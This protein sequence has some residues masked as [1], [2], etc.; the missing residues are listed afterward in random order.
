MSESIDLSGYE[1]L[2]SRGFRIERGWSDELATQ[3]VD[4]SQEPEIRQF[5]PSDADERF[6]TVDTA[7]EWYDAK[8]PSVYAL[9]RAAQLAGLIWFSHRPRPDLAADYT[10][11]IRMYDIAR[12]KGLAEPFIQA[13]E[14]D[15]RSITQPKAIWLE[16]DMDNSRARNLYHKLGYKVIKACSAR[17]TMSR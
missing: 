15:F 4:A 5:T 8:R 16:T 3:L 12:G 11:A 7:N 17:I 14:A 9:A 10:F 2:R 6:A 1:R 13:A